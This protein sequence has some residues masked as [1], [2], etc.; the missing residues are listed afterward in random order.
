MSAPA[1][2]GLVVAVVLVGGVVAV[3][4]TGG[5]GTDAKPYLGTRV[6]QDETV[7]TRFW[8]VAVHGAEVSLAKAE[9]RVAVTAMNKQRRT[10]VS[11]TTN[12]LVIRMP[13]GTP[14]LRSSCTSMRGYRF[15]PLIPTD[16]QCVFRF[17]DNE[18]QL[19]EIPE[20]GPFD[21]EFIVLDQN[22]SDNFV[23]VPEPQ[24]GEAAGWL[25]LTVR[26]AE[27]DA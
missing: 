8:N 3:W 24:A 9:I 25:P 22:M 26:V 14:M 18:L 15:G 12:M 1:I 13:D 6:L 16:A 27:E 19:D 23:T 5:F 10:A 17:E 11:L 20:P 4:G 21:I 2:V 7:E